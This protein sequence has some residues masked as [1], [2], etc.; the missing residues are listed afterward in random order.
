MSQYVE[1]PTK[2]F[3]AGAAIAQHLRVVLSSGVLAVAGATERMLGT[4]DRPSFASGDKVSVRL[5]TAQGTRKMVAS[6]AITAGNPVYAA[7]SGKVSADGSVL[8]GYALE[9]ATTDGDVIEVMTDSFPTS[10][11]VIAGAQQALSGAGAVNVTT[12]YT[13]VTTT[14]TDALTLADGTFPGQ[15]KKVKLIVDGGDGTLTPSNFT[16]GSTI[17]FADAGDYALLLWDGDSWTAV[18]VGND[19]DG[20]T[21]HVIA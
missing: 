2:A 12:F 10:G 8:E 20:A 6:E 17:T 1:T 14:G 13:A 19:A 15:L 5:R 7:A 3:Q 18:E 9:A 21:A 4:M 11:G 16:N